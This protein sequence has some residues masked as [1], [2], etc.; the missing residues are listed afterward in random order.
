ME[1]AL[2]ISGRIVAGLL[3]LVGVIVLVSLVA[4][5]TFVSA[6]STIPATVA[7]TLADEGFYA[8]AAEA[9]LNVVLDAIPEEI[10]AVG[11]AIQKGE[12]AEG[13]KKAGI[14]A[15][16]QLIVPR[17]WLQQHFV[18]TLTQTPENASASSDTGLIQGALRGEGGREVARLVIGAVR[19]CTDSE[20][21][22]LGDSST[23]NGAAS[24]V[25]NFIC[26][27]PD[28][29]NMDLKPVMQDVVV[30][31]LDKVAD[32]LKEDVSNRLEAVN[33][34]DI[35]V[36]TPLG[37]VSLQWPNIQL[38][39]GKF[40]LAIPL[41]DNVQ[42][43][44]E[45]TMAEMQAT[46]QAASEQINNRVTEAQED[47]EA[48]QNEIAASPTPE[49]PPTET[50]VVATPTVAAAEPS[51]LSEAQSRISTSVEA[52]LT[53]LNAR[54]M[55]VAASVN[56]ILLLVC[57]VALILL[58]IEILFLVRDFKG[59][60]IWIG[61]VLLA[62]GVVILL[63]NGRVGGQLTVAPPDANLSETAMQLRA[64]LAN[65]VST[66]V[67]DEIT[68][69]MNISGIVLSLIGAVLLGYLYFMS[70]RSTPSGQVPAPDNQEQ[71]V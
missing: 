33:F 1:K 16:S 71:P 15:I 3:V 43:T 46:V 8:Q 4:G 22:L 28:L 18:T 19:E 52:A 25:I 37:S 65:T 30:I 63:L 36:D 58:V 53:T 45:T 12:L 11:V 56:Q 59:V 17:E 29:S 32:E 70:R 57:G 39:T 68:R 14:A 51:R 55:E 50:P 47:L 35:A 13:I 27:P 20:V 54:L 64:T 6:A 23:D 21:Q 44:V 9:T 38:D 2:L 24:K 60:G 40:D 69:P 10:K 26:N 31:A 5:R 61:V 42:Q 7:R 66:A 41:P 49:V 62:S 67:H 48:L 34:D